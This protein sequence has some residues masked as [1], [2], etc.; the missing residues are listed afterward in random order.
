MHVFRVP[1]G[2]WILA[3]G[4][5][6]PVTKVRFTVGSRVVQCADCGWIFAEDTWRDLSARVAEHGGVDN[7]LATLRRILPTPPSREARRRLRLRHDRRPAD[8]PFFRVVR[9][10][11]GE[12]SAA[13]RAAAGR[14][15]SPAPRRDPRRST[16]TRLPTS[17]RRPSLTWW[18]A[19]MLGGVILLALLVLVLL[20]LVGGEPAVGGLTPRQ[21]AELAASLVTRPSTRAIRAPTGAHELDGSLRHSL[22]ADVTQAAVVQQRAVPAETGGAPAVGVEHAVALAGGRGAARIGGAEQ[23]HAATRAP[24]RGASVPSRW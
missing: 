23:R 24:R 8:G 1:A 10:Y 5:C 7:T 4:W 19:A 22:D 17:T 2:H 16:A 14:S 9:S 12:P 20:A 18:V 3:E 11:D 15:P 6:D 21:A 13:G